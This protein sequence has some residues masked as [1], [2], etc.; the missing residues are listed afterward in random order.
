MSE[1]VLHW[2]VFP[3]TDQLI[4]VMA[5]RIMSE[6]ERAIAAAGRFVVVLAGGST[7]RPVYARLAEFDTHW[8]QW[9]IYFGDERCLPVG[10][11]ERNDT[12][13]REALLD[14][15]S[16]PANQVHSVPA[17]LGPDAGAESYSRTLASLG[18][19]DLTILGL[20]EDGHTASLFPG[21]P[22][23]REP[24]A[25]DALAVHAAPKPPASRVSMS[26]ARLIRSHT[27]QLI[28]TGE[29]KR[30]ALTQLRDGADVPVR[31]VTPANGIDLFIDRSAAPSAV[32]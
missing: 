15:V 30:E 25:P 10:H 11:P 1:V 29:A 20:G 31:F 4:E 14:S 24:D 23:G 9:H 13:I 16:V 22:S 28:A 5:G 12:M 17:E 6:A 7:P 32:T 18:A 19:F 8:R 26:A 3:E 2:H 27:M 21:G